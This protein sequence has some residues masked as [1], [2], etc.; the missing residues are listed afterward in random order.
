MDDKAK[1]WPWNA[2]FNPSSNPRCIEV[3]RIRQVLATARQSCA[4]LACAKRPINQ[5]F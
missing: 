5:G 1:M 2:Q 4:A 3:W